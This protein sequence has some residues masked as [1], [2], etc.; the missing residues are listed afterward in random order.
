MFLF[1]TWLLNLIV[2]QEVQRDCSTLL[3]NMIIHYDYSIWLFNMIVQHD[4]YTWLLNLIVQQYV[5]IDCSTLLFNPI[6]DYSTRYSIWWFNIIVQHFCSSWCFPLLNNDAINTE[7]GS[8]IT[9]FVQSKQSFI[10]VKVVYLT[11]T[12]IDSLKN[13]VKKKKN[14]NSLSY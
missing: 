8:S 14:N 13:G 9:S 7:W 12:K 4:Y 6:Y 1:S 11:Q 10:L 5:H 3:C 2:Q